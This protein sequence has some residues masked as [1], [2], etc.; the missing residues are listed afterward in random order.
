MHHITFESSFIITYLNRFD[1]DALFM[2]HFYGDCSFH[3]SHAWS[4]GEAGHFYSSFFSV[5]EPFS[6]LYKMCVFLNDNAFIS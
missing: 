3:L 4:S 5:Q 2:I 6:C 1:N